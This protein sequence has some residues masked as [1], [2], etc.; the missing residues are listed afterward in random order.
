[1]SPTGSASCD[2]WKELRAQL[3]SIFR[4]ELYAKTVQRVEYEIRLVDGKLQQVRKDVQKVVPRLPPIAPPE[5]PGV[6]EVVVAVNHLFHLTQR[7]LASLGAALARLGHGLAEPF[8]TAGENLYAEMQKVDYKRAVA[9][10]LLGRWSDDIV[11][12]LEK[13]GW[14][15]VVLALW[16][17]F[18][19]ALWVQRR[20][21]A[22]WAML[23]RP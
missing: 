1:M 19:Y 23:T 22:A 15:F 4:H 5:I 7:A 17:V 9:L 3:E 18:S 8:D 21:S 20:L 11:G 13:F 12:L 6:K 14:L 16:L 2:E 10:E